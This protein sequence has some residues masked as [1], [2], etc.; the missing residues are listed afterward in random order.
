MRV[1]FHQQKNGL[2]AWTCRLMKSIAALDV[3][4]STVSIR[5]LVSG[6][7]SSMVCMPTLPKRGSTVGSSLSAALD[8]STPRG[9]NFA[10]NAGFRIVGMLGLLLGIEVIQIAEELIEPMHGRQKFVAVAEM[11]LTELAGGVTEWFQR[12]GDGDVLRLQPE[13]RAGQANFGHSGA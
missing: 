2:L 6:P 11:V 1:P 9:P 12:L 10:L 5:F 13:R 7:V 4:S 8:L 3:S